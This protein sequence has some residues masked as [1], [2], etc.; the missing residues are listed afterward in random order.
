MFYEE[1]GTTELVR[2][3]SEAT[4]EHFSTELDVQK[5]PFSSIAALQISLKSLKN[6]CKRATSCIFTKKSTHLKVTTFNHIY[7]IRITIL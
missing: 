5:K 6:T 7:R 1:F 3:S 2:I 4:K